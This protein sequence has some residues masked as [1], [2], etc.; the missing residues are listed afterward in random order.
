MIDLH[1]EAVRVARG[2][3]EAVPAG[4]RARA[5][6]RLATS[7]YNVPGSLARREALCRE[8][9]ELLDEASDPRERAATLENLQFALWRAENAAWRVQLADELERVA[10][11]HGLGNR[12][13]SAMFWRIA[14]QV[15]LGRWRVAS[16]EIEG[17][18]AAAQAARLP[19]YVGY[20]TMFRA[21][22]AMVEAHL[23]DAERL[24]AD[25]IA[26]GAGI[27]DPANLLRYSMA[28]AYLRGLQGRLE[29]ALPSLR[30]F[31]DRTP[32]P[33]D[34]I[35]AEIHAQI[36][37]LSA[38]AHHFDRAIAD[39]F[40]RLRAVEGHY[41]WPRCL[42]ALAVAG[43]RLSRRDSA[44]WLYERLLPFADHWLVAG[45]ATTCVGS[46]HLALGFAAAAGGRRKDATAHLERSLAAHESEGATLP[47]LV[48]RL[49]LGRLLLASADRRSRQRGV[50]HLRRARSD[51][52]ATQCAHLEAQI[53]ALLAGG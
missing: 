24:T 29:E 49:E 51:A 26:H 6:S 12:R 36:G 17:F 31:F 1:E 33:W 20:A 46:G 47:A 30:L 11:R 13:L 45:P 9:I 25:S 19:S 23:E 50:L 37:D 42:H 41:L 22:R 39:D 4:L 43:W 38:C 2:A 21:T 5:L 52:R 28:M 18:V 40:A 10:T 16:A 3:T 8:A 48:S 34:A 27:E 15:E 44:S 35:L 14:A 32:G 53:G 7:L